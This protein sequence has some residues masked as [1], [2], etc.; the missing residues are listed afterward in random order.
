[1]QMAMADKP[2]S[3]ARSTLRALGRTATVRPGWLSKMLEWSL[4]LLP[5]VGRVRILQLVMAGMTKRQAGG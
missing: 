4:S 5:R 1:M 2:A 3:V